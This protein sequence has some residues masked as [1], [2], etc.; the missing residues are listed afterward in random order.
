LSIYGYAVTRALARNGLALSRERRTPTFLIAESICAARRSAAP[1]YSSNPA[2]VHGGNVA[3][4]FLRQRRP[5]HP[6]WHCTGPGW[7]RRQRTDSDVSA[8]RL[9]AAH[10]FPV[11]G[12][13][14][15]RLRRRRRRA[16]SI[17]SHSIP[18]TSG[19]FT[20]AAALAVRQG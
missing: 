5:V 15:F 19:R 12:S 11:L 16:T 3:E 10:C 17:H 7:P 18:V 13:P 14:R 6:Q 9:G 2:A 4:G 8:A 1:C 20:A